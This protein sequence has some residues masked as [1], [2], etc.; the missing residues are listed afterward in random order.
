MFWSSF[1]WN[2]WQAKWKKSLKRN[3][4]LQCVEPFFRCQTITGWSP[5]LNKIFII[6]K[7]Q[8][9]Y[10]LFQTDILH[11][12]CSTISE[13]NLVKIFF[14]PWRPSLN[15]CQKLSFRQ[16]LVAYSETWLISNL[17][18]CWKLWQTELKSENKPV[19]AAP[20]VLVS[21]TLVS[22]WA[23]SNGFAN[24]LLFAPVNNFSNILPWRI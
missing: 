3:E 14:W 22:Q 8:F 20:I 15:K 23:R 1:L 13:L 24:G 12:Y 4:N 9:S 17:I 2:N 6:I 19:E 11:R 21:F 7:L 16:I 10:S 18:S 5:C